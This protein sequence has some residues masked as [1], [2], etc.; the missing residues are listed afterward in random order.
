[1]SKNR[2]AIAR[3]IQLKNHHLRLAKAA[4]KKADSVDAK[5]RKVESVL[6]TLEAQRD[7][8]RNRQELNFAKSMEYLAIIR[9][10]GHNI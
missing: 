6:R 2:A 4:Q 10:K 1:M 9:D 8:F 7:V 5:I 3:N